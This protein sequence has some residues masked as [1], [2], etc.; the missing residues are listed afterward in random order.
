MV[1]APLN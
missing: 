1:S